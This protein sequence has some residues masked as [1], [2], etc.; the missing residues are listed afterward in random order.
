MRTLRVKEG[1]KGE[2]KEI[3]KARRKEGRKKR[4]TSLYNTRYL[5]IRKIEIR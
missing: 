2:K 5:Y 1:R 3:W 4:L